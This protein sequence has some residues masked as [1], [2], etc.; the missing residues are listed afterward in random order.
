MRND[1]V[2]G[3]RF[4]D[5]E[6]ADHTRQRRKLSAAPEPGAACQS[7]RRSGPPLNHSACSIPS[8]PK[9]EAGRPMSAR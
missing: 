2:P 7:R 3:A 4:P 1:I 9:S 5:Y 8:S 6:L